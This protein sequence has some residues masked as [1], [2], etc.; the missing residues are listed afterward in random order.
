M[1]AGNQ[2]DFCATETQCK[3]LVKVRRTCRRRLLLRERAS[4]CEGLAR[5]DTGPRATEGPPCVSAPLHGSLVHTL[6]RRCFSVP[7]GITWVSDSFFTLL[8]IKNKP[9]ACAAGP[10]PQPSPLGERSPFGR[11]G[12][13]FRGTSSVEPEPRTVLGP[14]ERQT[15]ARKRCSRVSLSRLQGKTRLSV[16][17]STAP[18]RGGASSCIQARA[19]SALNCA[20]VQSHCAWKELGLR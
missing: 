7:T 16:C 12:P 14:R 11:P 8:F 2:V 4:P 19:A 6:H 5:A 1:D 13:W 9:V 10:A 15:R 17:L 3:V 20:A 18:G